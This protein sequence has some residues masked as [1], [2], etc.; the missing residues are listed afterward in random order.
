[1][2]QNQFQWVQCNITIPSLFD[3]LFAL[4]PRESKYTLPKFRQENHLH[5]VDETLHPVFGSKIRIQHGFSLLS[6]F[7]E[8]SVQ[9]GLACRLSKT[10][11][12]HS[13]DLVMGRYQWFVIGD[14]AYHNMVRSAVEDSGALQ[15]HSSLDVKSAFIAILTMH[16]ILI[17][18]SSDTLAY[19][20]DYLE[21][22]WH[23]VRD[24]ISHHRNSGMTAPPYVR[25]STSTRVQVLLLSSRGPFQTHLEIS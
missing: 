7:T 21:Q 14:K 12:Y 6:A 24:N 22:A 1:M 8:S 17:K 10:I 18:A 16:L 15:R 2:S 9:Q 19:C 13:F 11:I 5:A 23:Q 20:I 25:Y 4:G 3:F